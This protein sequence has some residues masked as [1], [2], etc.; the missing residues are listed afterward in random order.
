MHGTVVASSAAQLLLVGPVQV[1]ADG[2]V[3]VSA[4]NS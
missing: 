4:N 1:S 2:I 3:S